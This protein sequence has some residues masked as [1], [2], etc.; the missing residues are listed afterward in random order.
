M[1]VQSNAQEAFG[2]CICTTSL[3]CLDAG[4][5]ESTCTYTSFDLQ[6]SSVATQS[7]TYSVAH[8]IWPCSS[9]WRKPL[10]DEQKIQPVIKSKTRICI[11]ILLLTSLWSSRVLHSIVVWLFQLYNSSLADKLQ[12][13]PRKDLVWVTIV[14]RLL[15]TA[16]FHS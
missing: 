2:Q 14:S 10:L 8:Y 11:T 5:L 12:G 1:Q 15:M 7:R 16:G 3:H 4:L 6:K 9:D 13:H